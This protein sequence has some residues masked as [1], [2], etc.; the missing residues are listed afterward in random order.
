MFSFVNFVFVFCFLAASNCPWLTEQQSAFVAEE[1]TCECIRLTTICNNRTMV[2]NKRTAG[3]MNGKDTRDYCDFRCAK[4]CEKKI[5]ED[6]GNELENLNHEAF[7]KMCK[8]TFANSSE[9]RGGIC[10]I[11][12]PVLDRCENDNHK[13]LESN[14]KKI[15]FNLSDTKRLKD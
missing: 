15:Y 4:E 9:N 12:V 8:E 14:F 13:V 7:D 6:L 11:S 1:R 10:L 3:T 2:L 5:K